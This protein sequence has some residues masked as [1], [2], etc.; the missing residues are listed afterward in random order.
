MQG[1]FSHTPLQGRC[2][3]GNAYTIE[4]K[5]QRGRSQVQRSPF[6]VIFFSFYSFA[7]FLQI[8]QINN[9]DLPDR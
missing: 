7:I 9:S 1:A 2:K 5:K 3:N 8:S 4:Q 6:R